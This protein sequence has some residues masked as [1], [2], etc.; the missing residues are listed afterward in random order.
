MGNTIE[1]VTASFGWGREGDCLTFGD[2][3]CIKRT[4][5][6]AGDRVTSG[7]VV[8]DGDGGPWFDCERAWSK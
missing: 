7:I 1:W 4:A 8:G 5:V 6:L 3:V 2:D